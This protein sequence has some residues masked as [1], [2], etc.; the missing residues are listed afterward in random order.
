MRILT[1]WCDDYL[2]MMMMICD[3]CVGDRKRTRIPPSVFS[4]VSRRCRYDEEEEES[5]TGM[6]KNEHIAM[7]WMFASV[8]AD[9]VDCGVGRNCN[10]R[11]LLWKS[12]RMLVECN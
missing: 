4:F 3:V 7:C 10:N 6:R 9:N 5:Q 1:V 12:I 11:F 2:A 8:C